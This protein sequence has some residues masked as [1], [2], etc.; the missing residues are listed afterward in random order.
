MFHN[1]AS[2]QVYELARLYIKLFKCV[3]TVGFMKLIE[4][5]E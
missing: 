3:E 5:M 1:I 2:V 4:K